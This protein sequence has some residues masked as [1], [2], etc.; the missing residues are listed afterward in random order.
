EN[1]DGTWQATL[2][3]TCSEDATDAVISTTPDV[4]TAVTVR[5]PEDCE[6]GETP[7][8]FTDVRPNTMFYDEIMWMA[9]QGYAQGW[10]DGTFRPVT[11]VNRDAMAAFLYR[12]AGSPEVR[13]PRNQPF[14]DVRPGQEHYD[15]IIWAHQEGITTGWTER[16]G[17]RTFRPTQ[18][19]DR[20]AMAAFVYRYAG[21]PE[22]A[23][24]TQ[25]PFRDV[26]ANAKFAKEIA[27]AKE[28]GITTGWPNG[29]YRPKSPMNRDATAAFLYR[30]QEEQQIT[31]LSESD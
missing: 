12:M 24:P 26:P 15:A 2:A 4:G 27:W 31:Y 29:T 5:L 20:D 30:M 14:T 23:Q 13:T 9:N 21:S 25:A 18:T 19:I 22:F 1:A 17:T 11:S 7:I 3:I 28:E 10:P 6:A 16:N 8:S